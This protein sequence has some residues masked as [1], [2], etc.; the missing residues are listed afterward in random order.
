MSDPGQDDP[1]IL[2]YFYKGCEGTVR[3]SVRSQALLKKISPFCSSCFAAL[4]VSLKKQSMGIFV[5]KKKEEPAPHPAHQ[6][7]QHLALS[8]TVQSQPESIE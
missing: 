4:S 3:T 6:T 8:G 5:S 2:F 7:I 1:Q